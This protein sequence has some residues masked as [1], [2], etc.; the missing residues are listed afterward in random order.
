MSKRKP[1]PREQWSTEASRSTV[2]GSLA[3]LFWS[4]LVGLGVVILVLLY[5]G[6]TL[7]C[8]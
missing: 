8:C 4:V 7:F 1:L 2:K 6:Q 5:T 3:E